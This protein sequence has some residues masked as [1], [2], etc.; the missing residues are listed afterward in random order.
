MLS[1]DWSSDVCSSDLRSRRKNK[2]TRRGEKTKDESSLAH[3]QIS[4]LIYI[5][6]L[7][8]PVR[9]DNYHI[10]LYTREMPCMV[11]YQTID[12]SLIGSEPHVVRE[13]QDNRCSSAHRFTPYEKAP[14]KRCQLPKTVSR[15]SPKEY[16]RRKSA[17]VQDRKSTRLNSSHPTTSRMPSSA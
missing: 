8:F 17:E 14:P 10:S 16:R 11:R 4:S 12:A 15:K 6:C 9:V 7:T 3:L 5:N 13:Q 2:E 1:G